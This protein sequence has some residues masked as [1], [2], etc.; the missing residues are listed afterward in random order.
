MTLIYAF[1]A[2]SIVSLLSLVGIIALSM[3]E[4]FLDRILFYLVSFSAGTILGTA[5]FDLLPESIELANTSI[6]FPY[7]GIGFLLF[8]FIERSIYWYHG[9][10]HS[11]DEYA[12]SVKSYVYLNLVGDGIHNLIDGMVITTTF[13]ISIPLGI[14][15][16][17]AIIFHELP[18]EIGDFAILIF[19][20]FSKKRALI[21]NF[22][23]AITS[24]LGLTIAFFLIN[25]D[26]FGGLLISLSAGGFIY[27]SASE[28]LPEIR[29]EE[30]LR[31]SIVQYI[32]FVFG[33]FFVWSFDLII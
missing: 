8:F 15:A 5:F 16:T 6:I 7:I 27:L 28:L 26:G 3:K 13:L 14:S 33:M 4:H 25:I 1:I 17:I 18:Q 22:L 19:G 11:H 29:K 23:T 9:H 31:K 24:F 2:I 10:G 21:F 32:I 12:G 30:I 20:G